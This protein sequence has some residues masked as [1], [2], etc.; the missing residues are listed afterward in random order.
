MNNEPGNLRAGSGTLVARRSNMLNMLEDSALP[1]PD[2]SP[3]LFLLCCRRDNLI[4]QAQ[5]IARE[6][7]QLDREIELRQ[8]KYPAFLGAPITPVVDPMTEFP[9]A[10]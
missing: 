6:I 5:R 4:R 9:H 8:G 10:S 1:S 2:R 3:A 7:E